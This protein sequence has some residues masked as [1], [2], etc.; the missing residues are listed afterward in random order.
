MAERPVVL[1]QYPQP[2][3]EGGQKA[4]LAAE[5]GPYVLQEVGFFGHT[6]TGEAK[7]FTVLAG[8]GAPTPTEGWVKLQKVQR[9]QRTSV[10]V[11]EGYDPYVLTVPLLFDAVARTIRR[12]VEQDIQ[13]LEWMAGR[14]PRGEPKGPPPLVMVYSTDSA[15]NLTN[16]VPKQFQT[17]PGASQQWYVGPIAL[18]PNPLRNRPGD[19]IRQAAT[20]TLTEAVNTEQSVQEARAK[21]EE[22]K[23]KFRV[24]HSTKAANT[25][26]KVAV[27]LGIAGAW[28]AILEANRGVTTDPEKKL[29]PGTR[30]RIPETAYRQVAR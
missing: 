26:K 7:S 1:R 28:K 22:V 4:E 21:R 10:T 19:R 25:I 13:T 18:D 15:G 9:F 30:I 6:L 16:L 24:V 8:E 17:V 5:L 20:V 12:N 23:G 11:P 2:T 14:S 27:S 29:N 3:T